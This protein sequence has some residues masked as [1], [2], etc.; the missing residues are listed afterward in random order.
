MALKLYNTMTRSVDPFEPIEPGKVSLYTCGPTVYNYAHIGNL[1]TYVF[2]DV[3]VRVLQR[4]GYDVTR[5]MNVTDVGHLTDDGDAGEDKMEKG[6]ARE[7]KTVWEIAQHY[8]DAFINDMRCLN[9]VEPS[10]WCRAT[11]EIDTQKQAVETLAEKGY[12][13]T[14]DDGIYFDTSKLA[15]YGKLARLDVAGLQAGQRVEMGQKKNPTDFA[16]WKFS[17]ADAQRLMEWPNPCGVEGM[18]FPGWHIE[19]SAM[20]IRY[21]GERLDIHCGGVD[22]VNV[23]H[24]NEIAQAEASLGHEWCNWWM[25]GEFLTMAT[26]DGGGKMSKSAGE[27]LTL[28]V[29]QERGYDP[30][31]YRLLL[32][33]AHYRQ[34]LTFRWDSL[35]AAASALKNLRRQVRELRATAQDQPAEP[36][37]AR[38][39]E[40][41]AAIEDDLNMPR[42]QAAMWSTLKDDASAEAKLAT[43]LSMDEVLG[44]DI[45]EMKENGLREDEKEAIWTA[46]AER[47]KAKKEKNFE[48]ADKCRDRVEAQFNATISDAQFGVRVD[49]NSG[50]IEFTNEELDEKGS[51]DE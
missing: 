31:A 9:L 18:G 50:H 43:V 32:L 42:A 35:D 21:L 44:L 37:E 47:R 49:F 20:A 25:H 29:L 16:V 24:T 48:V 15:D 7:G 17:P 34:Q 14:T 1:R 8:W 46:L 23:H 2:E 41:T 28:A 51:S 27:F 3:L 45:N 4:C 33:G 38:L 13:Y 12:T 36:I 40:F 19:C 11:D 6:A 22:H 39:A 10:I 30:L 5:V 26:E